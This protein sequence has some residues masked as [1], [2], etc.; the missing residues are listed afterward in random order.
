MAKLASDRPDGIE[1]RPGLVI[2]E[3]EIEFRASR[4]SGPGGQNVNKVNTRVELRFDLNGSRVLSDAEKQRI[5]SRLGSRLSTAGVVRVTA[6]RHRTRLQN[7]AAARARLAE[8]LQAALHQPRARRATRPSRRGKERRL[9][10]KRRRSELK[11][12]R[13]GRD[14]D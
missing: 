1:I 5:A 8:L 7:E 2:P 6:Q 13:G 9:A 14:P 3:A 10:A 12:G 4:S 11:R